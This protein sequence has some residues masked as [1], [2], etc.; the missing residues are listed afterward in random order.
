MTRKRCSK[1]AR[2][3]V[4]AKYISK[5]GRDEP[6]PLIGLRENGRATIRLITRETKI[7]TEDADRAS[8]GFRYS[9]IDNL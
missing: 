5:M 9:D 2:C 1:D 3:F 6:S 8:F 4:E 7:N